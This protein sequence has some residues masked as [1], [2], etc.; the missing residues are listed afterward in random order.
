[1][2][3]FVLLMLPRYLM[4]LR[5]DDPQPRQ[6]RQRKLVANIDFVFLA[7]FLCGT[8][9]IFSDKTCV[10]NSPLT[11]WSLTTLVLIELA[12]I[13]SPFIYCIL[14]I[15]FLPCIIVIA[16]QMHIRANNVFDGRMGAPLSVINAIPIVKYRIKRVIPDASPTSP[17]LVESPAVDAPNEPIVTDKLDQPVDIQ[18]ASSSSQSQHKLRKFHI[19]PGLFKPRNSE[20]TSS[21]S[22]S[23]PRWTWGSPQHTGPKNDDRNVIEIEQEDAVCVICLGEYDDGE[24][25]KQLSC[26]HH[27]HIKCI[28]DWLKLNAKC[29]LCIKSL[30]DDDS[31]ND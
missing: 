28:D 3:L 29:P 4:L 11:F 24:S 13:L 5:S 12:Y 26:K 27:F 19:L 2:F 7:V 10:D 1:M 20:G 31:T 9:A 16:R 23:S 8:T 15:L 17:D 14:F 18:Q 25:L 6:Q 30:V 22:I 21:P